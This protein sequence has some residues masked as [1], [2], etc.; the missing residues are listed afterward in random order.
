[1]PLWPSTRRL[2]CSFGR[3]A[4]FGNGPLDSWPNKVAVDH[5]GNVYVGGSLFGSIDI[6]P[7]RVPKVARR[8]CSCAN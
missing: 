4:R 3:P 2:V 7:L 1:M 6:G 5:Q 8:T